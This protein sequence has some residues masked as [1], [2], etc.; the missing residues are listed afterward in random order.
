M[1]V[2][3]QRVKD[4]FKAKYGTV[5]L[6]NQRLD[7]LAAK[8]APKIADDAE[9]GVID[10]ELDD[11][12]EMYPFLEMKKAED[13][14]VNDKKKQQQEQQN[15]NQDS[16]TNNQNSNEQ[17]QP[18][19]T[20]EQ[21]AFLK[22]VDQRLAPVTQKLNALEQ[23]QQG[24]TLVQKRETLLKEGK[25]LGIPDFTL[26]LIPV[27]EETNVTEVL[28]GVG[29]KYKEFAKQ[30]KLAAFGNDAP[31]SGQPKNPNEVSGDMK[32]YLAAKKPATETGK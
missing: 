31:P 23:Q 4:R 25:A 32:A 22:L 15:P 21:E 5:S 3:V 6:S 10:G 30:N 29:E 2:E 11:L 7:A 12:N 16:N 14:A 17:N 8:L 27:T 26:E 24:Q 13:R 1:A 28:Q 19:L 9:D 20:P 18:Q